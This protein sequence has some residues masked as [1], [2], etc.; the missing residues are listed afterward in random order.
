[1]KEF[2]RKI[3]VSGAVLGIF[4][5]I[6][7]SGAGAQPTESEAVD[8]A[9]ACRD[10]KDDLERLA[11]LDRATETL[12]VTRIVREEAIA[13]K[14]RE[15]RTFFGLGKPKQKDEDNPLVTETPEEFG[16][17]YLPENLKKRDEKRL[18]EIT[19]KV[20]EFRVNQFGKVTVTLENGQVW[21]QLNSDNKRLILSRKG[22]LYTAKVKRAR[23]GNYMLTVNELR[24]TIRVRRIK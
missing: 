15:E 10:I 16:G 9:I 23:F 13:E 8:A 4:C 11:C 21:R 19:S 5:T 12:V 14:K 22:K 20:A 3:V 7:L 17:E 6:G 24:R 1:M 18:K 2:F